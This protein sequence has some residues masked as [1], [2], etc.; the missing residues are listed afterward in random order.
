MAGARARL[1]AHVCAH[2]DVGGELEAQA[3]E[4]A[5]SAADVVDQA[6]GESHGE[7]QLDDPVGARG[8][9]RARVAVDSGVLEDGGDVVGY[10]V[11]SG[12]LGDGLHG[13]QQPESLP[14][15]GVELGFF[16]CF[17][18]GNRRQVHRLGPHLRIDAVEFDLDR[19]VGDFFAAQTSEDG[20]SFVMPVP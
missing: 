15:V 7:D 1:Q 9:E 14:V 5:A 4:G 17:P 6:P 2:V 20:P 10:A 18:M 12:P 19:W 11:A 8:Y 16:E 3:C 13:D